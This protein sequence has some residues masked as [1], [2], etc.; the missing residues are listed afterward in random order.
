MAGGPTRR[1]S[2]DGTQ[3]SPLIGDWHAQGRQIGA[4]QQARNTVVLGSRRPSSNVVHYISAAW[5]IVTSALTLVILV[6]GYTLSYVQSSLK[7]PTVLFPRF[8]P[9]L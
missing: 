3:F 4:E 9:P 2:E 1:G 8:E 7:H 5:I 6:I